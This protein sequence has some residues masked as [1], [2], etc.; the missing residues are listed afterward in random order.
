MGFVQVDENTLDSLKSLGLYA[1]RNKFSGCLIGLTGSVGKT[2]T[3]NMIALALQS[4]GNVYQSP[5]NWNNSIGVGLSL[6][7]MPGNV[8]FGVLELGMSEKGEILELARMCR[9]HVRVV[10][11]VAAAHLE[12]FTSIQE[13]ALAKGEIFKEAK[14]GDVCVLNADDPLVMSLPV[15]AGVKKVSEAL[16]LLL[17]SYNVV[18][19]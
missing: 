10:L 16:L 3:R 17:C 18:G 6:I 1:R 11:N 19:G 13:V 8:D 14:P 12:N 7:G 5:V 15:P 4:V 2:T 9:P